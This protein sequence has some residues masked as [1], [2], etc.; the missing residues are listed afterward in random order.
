MKL[1]NM[2]YQTYYI[3]I[4]SVNLAHYFA[5]GYVCPTK[6]IQ[7]RAEDLQ[8]KF[9]N[10]LLLSNSKFTNETNCCLEVVLD[11]QEVALPISKNFFIL[12]CPLPISRVKA[13]FFDDK[14]QASVTIF[15]ITSGAAYLPSNLITVDLGSTR[16]DSKEL[17][18]ARISNL[19]LDWSNKLDKLNKLLGGFSLMRLGGNEYQNYPPNYFFALS[20]INTLI[21]DEIVNQ[22]IEV[23]NSYEWAMMETDKHSHYSKAIYSTITKEILESFAKNDGVQLVKSNGN[24]QIDKIPEHKSTYS[25]A[26]LA[27]YGINARKSV[28]DFISDLVSNKFSNRRKEGISMSFGINKGYDSFRKDYKTS[29]F[30]VGVKF[31]LNSQLDYYTIESIYQFVFNKKTNNNLF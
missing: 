16:I 7:N 6:Y 30:E 15:N 3:P 2:P 21:K 29:N 22:S 14:K 17:N 12:D 1:N 27:S 25:I 11:V 28:D 5:K 10:L 19:E 18:E 26:I 23:S 4:K 8:D 13:V 20:Q 9:N 31:M 24:I